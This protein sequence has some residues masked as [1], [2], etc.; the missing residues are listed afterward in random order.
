MLLFYDHYI[1]GS[2]Y[3]SIWLRFTTFSLALL[4]RTK[5]RSSRNN[6]VGSSLSHKENML[7]PVTRE[8]S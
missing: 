2:Y 5:V 3:L 1:V 8:D 6:P 4:V 7:T